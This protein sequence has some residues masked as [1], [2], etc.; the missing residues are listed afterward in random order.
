MVD[1]ISKYDVAACQIEASK[2]TSG[3]KDELNEKLKE[4]DLRINMISKAAS[5][6]TAKEQ[7]IFDK[8]PNIRENMIFRESGKR[9]KPYELFMQN[10]YS[11]KM[12]GKNKHDDAPDSLAMA[13]D[14]AFERAQKVQVFKRPF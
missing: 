6:L 4:N 5:P 13:V 10:V 2:A 8:A 11:F 7:R 3:Y 12:F 9:S 14:M 1:A